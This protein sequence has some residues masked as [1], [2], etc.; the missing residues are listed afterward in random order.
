MVK[1][2]DR[3]PHCS[4]CHNWQALCRSILKDIYS[5]LQNRTRPCHLN[6]LV[7]SSSLKEMDRETEK[8]RR[9]TPLRPGPHPHRS[10]CASFD[11]I[12]PSVIKSS[13]DSSSPNTMITCILQQQPAQPELD[14][15]LAHEDHQDHHDHKD[16]K[17]HQDRQDHQETE[18][19]SPQYITERTTLSHQESRLTESREEST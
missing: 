15:S 12:H 17:D 7:G 10:T 13:W 2:S 19:V 8:I 11:P 9:K 6:Q 3:I 5:H 18:E 1:T 4:F 14:A 16:H